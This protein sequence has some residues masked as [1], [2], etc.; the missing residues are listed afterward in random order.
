MNPQTK[1]PLIAECPSCDTKIRFLQSP[2]LG[3]NIAC[4]EC[5]EVLQIISLA[6]LELD[7][8][9]DDDYEEYVDED[10]EW[11]YEEEDEDYDY[12]D[13]DD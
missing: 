1:Q 10:E 9:D 6:P 2:K 7:W 13:D 4:S 12:D 5:G 11:G 8:A 3:E